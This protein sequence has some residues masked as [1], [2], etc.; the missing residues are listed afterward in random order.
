ML[1]I[2]GGVVDDTCEERD[3]ENSEDS[4]EEESESS[5]NATFEEK[6][7]A[8]THSA[9]PDKAILDKQSGVKSCPTGSISCIYQVSSQDFKS[10]A[11]IF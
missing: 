9:E 7:Q 5:K 6:K 8:T 10:A 2:E 1:V 11:E 3:D 4:S